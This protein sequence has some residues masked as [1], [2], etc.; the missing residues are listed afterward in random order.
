M[1]RYT[2]GG[3]RPMTDRIILTGIE[4]Y[5]YGGVTQEEQRIGQRY[6][7]GIELTLDLSRA[8]SSDRVKDTVHYGQVHDLAVS[9][10]RERSFNLIESVAGRIAMGILAGFPVEQ[11]TVRVDKLLPPIDG[12]VSAAGVELTRK[13]DRSR[14]EA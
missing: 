13:R 6:R 8:A 3:A 2:W 12:V 5:A 1:E 7:V 14:A 11:V 4:A 10:L 9:I